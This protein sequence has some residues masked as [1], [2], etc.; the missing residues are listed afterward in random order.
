[1][2]LRSKNALS[3]FF[4]VPTRFCK[5][6]IQTTEIERVSIADLQNYPFYLK[7][8]YI[9]KLH[10]GRVCPGTGSR[11]EGKKSKKIQ[12]LIKKKN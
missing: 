2:Q 9:Q 12:I 10:T 3:H 11:T 4:S 1:M 7:V 5:K 8:S 6:K